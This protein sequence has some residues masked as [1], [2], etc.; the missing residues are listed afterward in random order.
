MEGQAL[1]HDVEAAVAVQE[2]PRAL[3]RDPGPEAEIAAGVL[4][5]P[6]GRATSSGLR[7]TP[8]SRYFSSR[9]FQSGALGVPSLD[10]AFSIAKVAIFSTAQGKC[11]SLRLR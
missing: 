10:R 7:H 9:L 3:L 2:A 4:R 5:R 1:A 8:L 11:A 6:V